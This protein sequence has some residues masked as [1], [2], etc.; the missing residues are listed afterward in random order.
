MQLSGRVQRRAAAPTDRATPGHRHGPEIVPGQVPAGPAGRWPPGS[1]WSR[2]APSGRPGS[3]SG[4]RRRPAP[5]A[6]RGST[7]PGRRCQGPVP[8]SGQSSRTSHSSS[9]D[10]GGCGLRVD[11]GQLGPQLLPRPGLGGLV[12]ASV[13]AARTRAA[14]PPSRRSGDASRRPRPRT[15]PARSR[16]RADRTRWC[17]GRA[18][19]RSAR[20]GPARAARRRT[21]G[22]AGWRP[23]A[24]ATTCEPRGR[25]RPR[26][27]T[28]IRGDGS[29]PGRRPARR[30]R[31]AAHRAVRRAAPRRRQAG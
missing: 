11:P 23:A 8:T 29:W 28:L 21:G 2:P 4:R 15:A 31:R 12:L 27:H 22:G 16:C 19:G 10:P 6:G 30:C 26:T 7:T 17:P 14:R 20:A 24:R 9:H 18:A 25:H 13:R 3:R 1:R 5:A